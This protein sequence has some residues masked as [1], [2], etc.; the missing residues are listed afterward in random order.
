MCGDYEAR[1]VW[2]VKEPDTTPRVRGLLVENI[3]GHLFPRYNPA[4]AGTTTVLA[5]PSTRLPIQP[6]V[7]GDYQST[8]YLLVDGV[9]TTPRVRGLPIVAV[10][11]EQL[12]RYNPACAGTTALTLNVFPSKPIQPRVCGDYQ[13]ILGL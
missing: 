1:V 3:Q 8:D 7:C 12:H 9:D 4:C 5:M 13:S 11:T 2:I 6:R 10:R